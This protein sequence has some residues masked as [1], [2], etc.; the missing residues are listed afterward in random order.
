MPTLNTAWTPSPIAATQLTLSN[1]S[2]AFST[3]SS[4]LFGSVVAR[5]G[6]I[7]ACFAFG[8]SNRNAL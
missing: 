6:W 5:A 8:S 2:G 4:S 3:Q 1:I 7:I